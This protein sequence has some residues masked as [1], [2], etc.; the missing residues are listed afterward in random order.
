MFCKPLNFHCICVSMQ[1]NKYSQENVEHNDEKYSVDKDV[2]GIASKRGQSEN[3]DNLYKS[4]CIV[5]YKLQCIN[6]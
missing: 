3:I 4:I 2:G 6:I 5:N 1:I